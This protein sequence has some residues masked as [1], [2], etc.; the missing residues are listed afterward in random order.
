[1]LTSTVY[2]YVQYIYCILRVQYFIVYSICTIHI[3]YTTQT[4][5]L[6]TIHTVYCIL[7]RQYFTVILKE[8]GYRNRT[9][10]LLDQTLERMQQVGKNLNMTNCVGVVSVRCCPT[11]HSDPHLV[12]VLCCTIPV[13][14]PLCIQNKPVLS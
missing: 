11:V 13:Y 6:C 3:L 8:S 12:L 10:C 14:K 5:Q 9:T 2:I 1:V 7:R 4:V